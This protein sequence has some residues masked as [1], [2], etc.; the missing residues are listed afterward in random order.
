VRII[1]FK[2]F[3][4]RQ[5]LLTYDEFEEALVRFAA[6]KAKGTIAGDDFIELALLPFIEELFTQISYKMPGR[7]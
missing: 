6:I 3:C 7:F 4:H 5:V 2:R 1:S